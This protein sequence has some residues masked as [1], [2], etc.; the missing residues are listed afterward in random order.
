MKR[1][2]E[3]LEIESLAINKEVEDKKLERAKSRAEAVYEYENAV[4][5][6]TYNAS[7]H[8]ATRINDKVLELEI[9]RDM[10]ITKQRISYMDELASMSESL[11]AKGMTAIEASAEAERLIAVQNATELDEIDRNTVEAKLQRAKAGAD[12]IFAYE[13][14]L[15]QRDFNEAIFHATKKNDSIKE[16]ELMIDDLA[17]TQKVTYMDRLSSR[18]AELRAQ[19]MS[20][21]QAAQ[22]AE[23]DIALAFGEERIALERKLEQKKFDVRQE[24]LES[25]ISL[26]KNVANAVFGENKAVAAA[27]AIVD[28]YSGAVAALGMRPWTY[29]NYVNAA[30]VVVAGMANVRKILAVNKNSKTASSATPSQPNVSTSFGLVDVG[31]NAPIAEQVAMSASA[32]Q[33]TMNPTF[34]FTGDLDPEVMAI[35]VNQGSNAISSRTLGVGI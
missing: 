16:L 30:A 35:K 14:A 32:P 13:M 19:G 9:K 22:Q 6:R 1:T 25:Y 24:Y 23:L 7:I 10:V 2:N 18:S 12:A 27:S 5:M 31:T 15:R 21:E 17:F 33:Q 4:R 34:V 28:T 26:A 11:R 8:E 3:E 20:A 29:M